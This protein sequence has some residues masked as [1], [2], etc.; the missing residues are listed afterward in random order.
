MLSEPPD[1]PFECER[2]R[3]SPVLV[4]RQ[5]E[6][7][8]HLAA[9]ELVL[10]IARQ[11]EDATTRGEDPPLLVADHESRAGCRVV[12]VDQLE[13]ETEAAAVARDGLLRQPFLAIVIDRPFL[14]VRADEVGHPVKV[15]T[16]VG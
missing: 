1:A 10:A 7:L 13:E 9:H 16:A 6:A 2:R 15:A 8:H 14:A 11:L 4:A 5:R 3:I 12:V